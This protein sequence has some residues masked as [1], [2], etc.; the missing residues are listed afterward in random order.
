MACV[1]PENFDGNKFRAK[2]GFILFYISG[3][4]LYCPS[5]PELT[6]EDLLDCC[7]TLEDIYWDKKE[8]AREAALSHIR[9]MYDEAGLVQ[10]LDWK[11]SLSDG[12]AKTKVLEVQAW[13]TYVWGRYA[14]YRTQIY[15]GESPT[16][17]YSDLICP[18]SF[19]DIV[20]AL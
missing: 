11:F 20:G 17:D 4:E 9:E 2:Y 10:L 19:F 1:I 6:T 7:A 3:N 15:N 12:V 13:T 16:I 5:L 8:I 18:H 14:T